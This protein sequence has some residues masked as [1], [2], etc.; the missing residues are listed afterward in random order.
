MRR[1]NHDETIRCCLSPPP[2]DADR[3]SAY[4]KRVQTDQAKS[5]SAGLEEQTRV[6]EEASPDWAKDVI[7]RIWKDGAT[8]RVL[9]MLMAMEDKP[10][11]KILYAMQ[12]TEDEEAKKLCEILQKIGDGDPMTSILKDAAKEP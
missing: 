4:E 12:T 11:A 6:I 8:Q 7:L 10:R 2:S 5:Q 3:I 1:R 9:Q